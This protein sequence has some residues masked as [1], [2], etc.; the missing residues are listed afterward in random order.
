MEKVFC[1]DCRF[2]QKH[3]LEIKYSKCS[4]NYSDSLTRAHSSMSYCQVV[5][6]DGQCKDY[7]EAPEGT[8]LWD[9]FANWVFNQ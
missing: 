7:E 3:P 9:R 1:T 4:K 8:S 6:R 2:I 5:N